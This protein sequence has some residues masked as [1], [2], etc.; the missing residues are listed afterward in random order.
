MSEVDGLKITIIRGKNLV[1]RDTDSSDPYVTIQLINPF[2]N[3]K[4]LYKAKTAVVK[5]NLNPLFNEHFEMEFP[6][7][8]SLFGV[9]KVKIFDKDLMSADDFMGQAILPI[10][11]IMPNKYEER[12]LKLHTIPGE[13]RVTG[14]LLIG[15]ELITDTNEKR[16]SEQKEDDLNAAEMLLLKI[17]GGALGATLILFIFSY[18]FPNLCLLL[19]FGICLGVIYFVLKSFYFSG[20]VFNK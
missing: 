16:V 10:P 18:F 13:D 15:I 20:G 3:S 1:P 9:L 17:G 6:S 19:A 12:W 11:A 14:K 5:S 4:P 2:E 8:F 7:L